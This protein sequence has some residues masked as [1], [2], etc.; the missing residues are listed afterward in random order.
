MRITPREIEKLMLH[1]AGEL[2]K[3]RKQRGIKLNYTE[4]VAYISAE[5]LELAREGKSVT[6]LMNL[7]TKLL[8]KDDVMDG[9]SEMI[10]EVQIEATFP[11]GTKLV[12]VHNPIK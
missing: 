10:H 1:Y 3:Q 7:G 12:T 5:L 8:T 9:V 2:A 4:S 11:D 6:E